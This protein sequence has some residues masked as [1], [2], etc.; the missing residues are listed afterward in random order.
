MHAATA[1]SASQ[2]EGV[3]SEAGCIMVTYLSRLIVFLVPANLSKLRPSAY[4]TESPGYHV[5]MSLYRA[6]SGIWI[7]E[8]GMVVNAFNPNTREA[9]AG[10]G[11]RPAWSM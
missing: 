4:V 3:P 9:E 2:L 6:Q 11:S 7:Q 10:E 1:T 8:P 5:V